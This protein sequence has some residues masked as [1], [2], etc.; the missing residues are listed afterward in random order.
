MN[1]RSGIK[2]RPPFPSALLDMSPEE[3]AT[4]LEG[5]GYGEIAIEKEVERLEKFHRMYLPPRRKKVNDVPVND[6]ED[7]AYKALERNLER[8]HNPDESTKKK[9]K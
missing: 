5:Q 7:K 3:Y 6:P 2:T 9:S 1:Q 4:Y 8:I